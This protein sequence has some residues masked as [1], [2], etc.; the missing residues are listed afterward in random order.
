MEQKQGTECPEGSSLDSVFTKISNHMDTWSGHDLAMSDYLELMG[1]LTAKKVAEYLQNDQAL[2]LPTIY[3]EFVEEVVSIRPVEPYTFLAF[4]PATPI[5]W[6]HANSP[7]QVP[8]IWSHSL[9]T[10]L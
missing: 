7:V 3:R 2:L 10:W 1:C 8:S 9:P 6:I 5:F 4:V